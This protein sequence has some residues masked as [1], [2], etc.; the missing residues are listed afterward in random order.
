MIRLN[1]KQFQERL[2]LMLVASLAI[3]LLATTCVP[4]LAQAAGTWT[5][6]GS[7]N[8][9]R[10]FHTST[11]LQTGEV[12]VAGGESPPINYG[13]SIA[14]AEIFNPATGRWTVT[15]DMTTEREA[16]TATLLLNGQALVAGGTRGTGAPCTATAELF[17]RATGKWTPT[18]SMSV[19]RCYFT[20]TLLPN[21]QVLVAGGTAAVQ[22]GIQTMASINSAELYT[23]STGTW[24]TTGSLNVARELASARMLQNGKVL[25]AGGWNTTN[26]TT[27]GVAS[28]EIFDPATGRWSFTGSG[29]LGALGSPLPN[30]GLLVYPSAFYDPATGTWTNT[31]PI[32]RGYLVAYSSF[33]TATLLGTGNVLL[34]GFR[35]FCKYGCFAT[36]N[37]ILYDFSTNT[38]SFTG[39]MNTPRLGDSAVLLPNGKVLVSGGKNRASNGAIV[40]LSSAE[41]Y[42][43]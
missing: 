43:P 9:V 40:W 22:D 39:S 21:G 24:Q 25:V 10:A 17:N 6:T 12:L 33:A 5:N 8:I 26:G 11:L 32:P 13:N 30:G 37:T 2:T 38:Y 1:L 27:T 31:G 3:G 18:G 41:L 14:N 35:Q 19:G 16:G 4:A 28:A 29:G 7:M 34:T 36:A 42:T 20:A 23:P 15:G